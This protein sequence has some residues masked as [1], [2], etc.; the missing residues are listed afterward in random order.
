MLYFDYAATTPLDPNILKK[1]MPFF[2]KEYGNPSSFYEFGQR[3]KQAIDNSRQT[4]AKTLN[5]LAKE[6]IFTGSGTESNNLAIFGTAEAHQEKGKHII[7]SNIEHHSVLYPFQKLEKKGFK[8]TYLPVS[9]EG[10]INPEDLKKALTKETILVSIIYASN[11]IGTIQ[12][13]EEIGKIIREYK[14]DKSSPPFFHVDACQ[15]VSALPIDVEQLNVDL[16]TLNAGKIYGPKGVGALYINKN[17]KITPQILG[18]GQEYGLRAGT[19]NV[20]GIV[21]LAE[22]LKIAEENKETEKKRLALL[23]DT[24]IDGVLK[25][26]PR[27]HLNGSRKKR[28]PNNANFSFDGIEGET[29]LLCL[30][31]KGVCA[32]SSSA[33][34]S[35]AL[36]SSHVL[37]ALGLSPEKAQGSLRLTLGKYTQK[38]DVEKILEILPPLIEELRKTS[39]LY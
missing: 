20:A 9:K 16:L 2:E 21:G 14:K 34:A 7:T 12:P 10:L 28:L 13:I 4:V 5:C 24:L 1:M 36:H 30:D 35:G 3:S 37:R 31:T 38:E 8:V 25:K 33:C 27:S 29:M 11:E 15:A 26:I 32:S 23:R 18:G 19:E 39:P 6:I 17:V 22:A